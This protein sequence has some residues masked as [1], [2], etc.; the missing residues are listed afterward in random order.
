MSEK[1]GGGE[2]EGRR[3]ENEASREMRTWK[4]RSLD[5]RV[6]PSLLSL[7]L[8]SFVVSFLFSHPVFKLRQYYTGFRFECPDAWKRVE[9]S[10]AREV[11]GRGWSLHLGLRKVV[12]R[13]EST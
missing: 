7:S 9:D 2:E 8:P 10:V 5:F 13:I 1:G 4:A 11:D 6:T 3:K 12:L